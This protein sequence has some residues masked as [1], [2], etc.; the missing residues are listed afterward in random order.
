[1]NT[2]P[3]HTAGEWYASGIHVQ[4]K[5]DHDNYVC[6]AEGDT[7]A[8]AEANARLIAASPTLLSSLENA[9]EAM[10][11]NSDFEFALDMAKKAIKQ[12]RGIK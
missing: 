4:T 3:Q 2:K 7:Q 12:A 9:V 5:A 6:K 10:T 11:I 1:M 8:Q